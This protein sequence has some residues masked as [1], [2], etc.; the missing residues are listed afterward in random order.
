MACVT[1]RRGKWAVDWRDGAGARR[2]R[3]FKTRGAAEDFLAKAIPESRQMVRPVVDPNLTVTAYAEHWGTQLAA[4]VQGATLK[5]RT[6]ESYA[7]QLRLHILPALGSERVR[8]LHRARV[9][10]FLV[11]KLAAGLAPRSVGVIYG[12]LRAMLSSAVDDGVL[13]ANPAARLGRKLRLAASSARRQEEIKAMARPQLRRFLMAAWTHERRF[14]AFFLLLARTG[15][16][17]GEALGLQWPD[18]DLPAREVRVARAVSDDGQRID[19]PKSGHGRTVDLSQQLVATLRRL[20][21][22]QKAEALRR[23]SPAP[24]WVFP[25]TRGTPLDPANV[26]KAFA[27]TLK[28]A[29]LPAHFTPHSLR[30]TFASILLAEGKSPAYVQAQLGHASITLTVDTYGKWLPKG[31]KA[32]VDSLDDAPAKRSGDRVVTFGGGSGESA[33]QLSDFES[34]PPRNRTANPLIKSQLLCQLS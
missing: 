16:R 2:A 30:H 5:P 12:T 4:M 20:H 3:F 22:G 1:K 14:Y 33:A 34:G 23:G 11:A 6:L 7:D 9:R 13:V 8:N 10:V 29:E 28:K 26:R 25:S 24:S 15:M 27:R 31:D 17:L 19:T 18:L 32:A 21:V